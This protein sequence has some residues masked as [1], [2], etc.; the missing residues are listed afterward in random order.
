VRAGA[1]A[2][3][4]CAIALASAVPAQAQAQ[5][6][7]GAAY[8]QST[9]GPPPAPAPRPELL[10]AAGPVVPGAVAVIDPATGLAAAPADA[11]LIV[12][13]IVWAGNQLVGKPYRYGGGHRRGFVDTGYDCSGTLSYALA[14]AGLLGAPRDSRTFARFGRPGE[15]VWVTVWTNPGHAFMEVAGIRLDTSAA[16]D[17]SGA[18][19]PRWRAVLRR[20]DGFVAR[21]P[22][23]L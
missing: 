20:T 2:A 15:G 12:Q 19:G 23:G 1:V 10:P 18:K 3:V 9:E 16:G 7:G 21:H 22:R 11:P 13:R 5:R 14:G 17:P 4:T 8:G 6:T